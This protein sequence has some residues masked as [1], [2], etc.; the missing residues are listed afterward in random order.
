VRLAPKLWRRAVV[1]DGPPY[2][3]PYNAAVAGAAID[4]FL[5][6]RPHLSAEIQASASEPLRDST[7]AE[8]SF[9]SLGRLRVEASSAAS[10]RGRRRMV[11]P[12]SNITSRTSGM[13]TMV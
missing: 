13:P 2:S 6:Q 12:S 8:R 10:H 11:G 9:L 7:V 4:Q 1:D 3:G 5:G